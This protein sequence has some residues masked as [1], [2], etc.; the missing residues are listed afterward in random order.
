M[1]KAKRPFIFRTTSRCI[2]ITA[3]LLILLGYMLMSGSGSTDQSFN[4][5]IFSPRRIIIAPMFC[6][7]GYLLIIIGIIKKK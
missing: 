7:S 6:L 2:I 1:R 3:C 4:P 5:D